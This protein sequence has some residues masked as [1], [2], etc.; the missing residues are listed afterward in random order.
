MHASPYSPTPHTYHTHHEH[1]IPHTRISYILVHVYHTT[2]HVAHVHAHTYRY[3]HIPYTPHRLTYFPSSTTDPT[4]HTCHIHIPHTHTLPHTCH[5]THTDHLHSHTC[6]PPPTHTYHTYL[7]LAQV[8][9]HTP[10]IHDLGVVAHT[11][12][13]STWEVKAGNPGVIFSYTDHLP[14]L[15]SHRV[16][17]N[18]PTT[19]KISLNLSTVVFNFTVMRST[20]WFTLHGFVTPCMKLPC[21]ANTI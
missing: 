10:Y 19:H 12:N 3:I 21:R 20:S 8:C 13:C 7:E 1:T 11:Y 2:T 6:I 5:T 14:E 18:Q 4:P 17:R 15:Q 16:N 9:T